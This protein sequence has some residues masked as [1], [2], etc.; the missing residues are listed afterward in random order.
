MGSCPSIHFGS[1]LES[2]DCLC[3]AH[4]CIGRAEGG[5]FLPSS[6]IGPRQKYWGN[7]QGIGAKPHAVVVRVN[8]AAVGGGRGGR[9]L[10]Y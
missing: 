3:M 4:P 8:A 10:T 7:Y 2:N 9:P 6:A 5:L 1:I